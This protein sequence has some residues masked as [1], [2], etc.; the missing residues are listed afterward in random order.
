MSRNEWNFNWVHTRRL[1]ASLATLAALAIGAVVFVAA[2]GAGLTDSTFEGND[3][4]MIVNHGGTDWSSWAGNPSLRT[5]LDLTSSSSDNAFTQG[6]H[7]DDPNVTIDAGSIPNSKADLSRAYVASET[8]AG[9]PFLYLAWERAS[10]SGTVNFDFELNQKATAGWTSSTTGPVTINR[11]EGD[12]LITYDFNGNPTG[13][14]E[15]TLLYWLTAGNGHTSSD[16]TKSGEKLPCWGN[17]ILLTP[18]SN[19]P[20]VGAVNLATIDEPIMGGGATLTQQLFGEAKINLG[21]PSLNVFQP[22]TCKAFGSVFVNSRSSVSFDS[23]MK[24]FIAPSPIHVSNCGSIELKKHWVGTSGN[25]TLNVGS[26]AGGSQVSQATANGADGTTGTTDVESGTYYLS[27]AVGNASDYASALSC[28]DNGSNAAIGSSSSVSAQSGHAVVCTFTNTRNQGSLELKKHWVG[29]A[30]D[31]TLKI[32]TA[33][34]GSQVASTAL[35]GTDGTTGAKPVD[36]RT[37]YVAEALASPPDYTST[38]ACTDGGSNAT[39]GQDGAIAVAAGHTVVCTYT[40]TRKGSIELKK[41]WVGTAGTATLNVGSTSGGHEVAQTSV[42]ADGSTGAKTVGAGTYYV[43]ES[44][45]NASDYTSSLLCTDNGASATVG[46]GGSVAVGDAHT[47]VC[48]YTNT[49]KQGSLELRK[50]WVGTAGDVTLAI[51]TA[52]GGAQVASKQ[53]SGADGTTGG[54]T[55]DTGTY[56]LSESL[57]TGGDYTTALACTNGNAFVAAGQDGSVVVG[58]GDVVVCPYTNTRKQGTIELKKH[59]VGGAGD[60]TLKIGSAAGG[61]QVTSK[62]LSADGTTGAQTVD[63]GSY[64]VSESLANAS[65]YTSSLPC[66]TGGNA[67]AV[68]Q[69]GAVAVGAAD[70]VLSIFP[71]RRTS[72]LVVRKN[73]GGGA[74]DVALANGGGAGGGQVA[75]KKLSGADG[76]TGAKPLEPATYFVSESLATGADYTTALAC[77]NGNAPVAAGQD[78]SVAVGAGDVVVCTYTNTRKQG[79]LELRKHW[80]GTAGDVTVAIGTAAGGAQVA[81]KQLSGADGTTGAKTL[82]T[83]TYYVSEAVANAADYTSAVACTDGSKAVAVGQNGSVDVAAGQD[84]VCTYTNTRKQGSLELEK[85]WVGGAGDVTLK[86]GSAA[87]GSQVTSKQVTGG[88]GT[89]G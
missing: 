27:E 22:N 44:I 16:C 88:D 55:L 87:G 67:V 74:G 29:G 14:A 26:S 77:T 6:T 17:R 69:D 80:I 24:D 76:T 20:A 82:D 84:V 41:H 53:L 2:S 28:T 11:T 3:G 64:Y 37:Y 12:V 50:H 73:W 18:T 40:N 35:S 85:H 39:V 1:R 47:V 57:A 51:G 48:T 83:G 81:S 46:Q 21:D 66:T 42:S 63:T 13:A 62:Q 31:V 59:W 54:K 4:D 8:V 15:L 71:T 56:Y 58:A 79:S 7:E 10:L 70:A 86:I 52:A 23:E 32:G 36:T 89:T 68:G 43:A 60:V 33:A 38:L 30:G 45:A 25:A 9:Q 34:G 5:L 61:S 78:G 19:P 75:S 65:A 49:R 72:S